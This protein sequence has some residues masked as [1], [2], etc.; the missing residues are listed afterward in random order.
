[1][2]RAIETILEILQEGAEGTAALLDVMLTPKSSVFYRKMNRLSYYGPKRFKDDWT[3]WY[4]KRQA[5]YS[6]LN[7]LKREGF[8]IKKENHRNSPW[9]I[10][11]Q[12]LA[13]LAIIKKGVKTV[14]RPR[15]L[16]Y[17][18][19]GG[20]ELI[21]VAFDVPE[22]ERKKRDWLRAGLMSLGYRMLQQS[23]WAG[24]VRIPLEFI[25]DLKGNNILRYVHIFSVGRKGTIEE[26][27]F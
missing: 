17:K 26:K 16:S 15:K 12:G 5:F 22:K 6:L 23:V 27:R 2:S 9:S 25:K 7:K 18:R 21:I 13:K 11:K 10:T 1:M 14:G 20:L 24:K 4:R 19:D 8:I 3:D